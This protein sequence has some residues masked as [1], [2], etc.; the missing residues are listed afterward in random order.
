M[1]A[2]PR[3]AVEVAGDGGGG[4]AAGMGGGLEVAGELVVL[5]D[6]A[7]AYL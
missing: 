1:E 6:C 5:D 4:G 2:C 3:W 7:R